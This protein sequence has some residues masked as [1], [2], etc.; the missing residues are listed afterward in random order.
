MTSAIFCHRL[1]SS[2]MTFTKAFRNNSSSILVH[3]EIISE[4]DYRRW[5]WRWRI[6]DYAGF[7]PFSCEPLE[8]IAALHINSPRRLNLPL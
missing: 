3:G 7:S 4:D 1:T 6:E 5:W 2:S 8:Q